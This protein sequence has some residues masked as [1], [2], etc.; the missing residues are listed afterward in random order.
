MCQ[1]YVLIILRTYCIFY[2]KC[3][4]KTTT[5]E[6][7]ELP[8]TQDYMDMIKSDVADIKNVGVKVV[9]FQWK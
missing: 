4:I 2:P 1:L 7:W 5:E 6:I 3:K 8:L 9:Q